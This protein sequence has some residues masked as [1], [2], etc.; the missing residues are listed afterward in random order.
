MIKPAMRFYDSVE[1]LP[2]GFHNLFT[3]WIDTPE[4]NYPPP[5]HSELV[6]LLASWAQWVLSI[7]GDTFDY[8]QQGLNWRL[9]TTGLNINQAYML[10]AKKGMNFTDLVTMPEQDSW[11]FKD[12][13]GVSGPSM[14]CDVFVMRMWKAAGIFGDLTNQIQGTEFTNWDAYSLNIFNAKFKRPPQC[15]TA[16]PDSQFC[17]LLGKYRMALPDYNSVIPYAHMR[18]RCPSEAPNYIKPVGC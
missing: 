6:M 14:V 5:L 15:V 10:A 17:Q 4:D 16:D 11:I 3:G 2:Y 7:E 1:G 12:S 9:G 8:L 18:E 13:N